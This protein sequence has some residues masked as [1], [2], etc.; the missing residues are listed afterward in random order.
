MRCWDC[1]SVVILPEVID[2]K[3]GE[4]GQLRAGLSTPGPHP[5]VVTQEVRC[6]CGAHYQLTMARKPGFVKVKRAEPSEQERERRRTW[7]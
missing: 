1:K 4:A 2:G 3:P 5:Q 6:G 7:E